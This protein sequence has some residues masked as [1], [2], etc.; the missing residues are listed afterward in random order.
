MAGS[1]VDVVASATSQSAEAAVQRRFRSATE[2]FDYLG[3]AA[4]QPMPP[5]Q[6]TIVTEVFGWLCLRTQIRNRFKDWLTVSAS[7]EA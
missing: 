1:S 5:A 7:I 2:C 6:G 3:P 4:Y